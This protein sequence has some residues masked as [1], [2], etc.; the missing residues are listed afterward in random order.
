MECVID[1][2]NNLR[3][4]DPGSVII[5]YNGGRSQNLVPP[6]LLETSAEQVL[7]HPNP[8]SQRWGRL[9]RFA[10]D[11]MKFA[12]NT[13]AFDIL[14]IVDSD[15]L[16]V[17]VGYTDFIRDN[18]VTFSGIGM[19]VKCC[20][21]QPMGTEKGPA[22][23]AWKEVEHWRPFLRRFPNGENKFP[24]WTFWP[25]T[26]FTAEAARAITAM[27]DF[28]EQFKET[29]SKSRIWAS[30]E[31][32]FPTL[33][34]LLGFD[35]VPNPCCN[36]YVR[37]KIQCSEQELDEVFA[38]PDVFW[39]HPVTRRFNDE[40]R[41]A[42]RNRSQQYGCSVVLTPA[43]ASNPETQLAVKRT[44]SILRFPKSAESLER[45]T[46]VMRS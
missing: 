10:V 14:T 31:V 5:L 15:Q 37:Y 8:Q 21:T 28:D 45:A 42:I 7:V 27:F 11:C 32:L 19:L 36:D 1:L 39:I 24:M 25:G 46:D 29:L 35:V 4:H 6:G 3:Y 17:R 30:E 26:V 22:K 40:L 34:A 20:N 16:S 23:A 41:V 33:V 13:C 9:H 2:V 38:R 18:V 43:D 12:L 44:D